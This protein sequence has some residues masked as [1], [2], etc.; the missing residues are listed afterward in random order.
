MDHHLQ[1]AAVFS[2]VFACQK[3]PV[4]VAGGDHVTCKMFE[5][6]SY[7]PFIQCCHKF[8]HWTTEWLLSKDQLLYESDFHFLKEKKRIPLQ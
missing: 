7:V 3:P 6:Q 2:I 1:S 5:D 8:G 4:K